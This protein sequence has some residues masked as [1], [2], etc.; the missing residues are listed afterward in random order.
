MPAHPSR[1][2]DPPGIGAYLV[3][4]IGLGVVPLVIIAA[5]LIARQAAL[6]RE[7]FERSLL[8]T[9]LALSVAVDRQLNGYQVMLET[10]AHTPELERGRID[11][12]AA[13]AAKV[14]AAHG[15]VFISLFDREGRQLFNTL[16]PA[17]T[18]LPTPFRDAR[19]AGD[20]RPPVGDAGSLKR[21]LASAGPVVSDLFHGLVADRLIFTVNIPVLREG[22]P[23]YVLNAAF[24]PEVMTR[25]LQDS[26]QFK[27]VRAVIYDRRGFIV[28]R[29]S[30]HE[31]YV[32][33][34]AG[35]ARREDLRGLP[36]GVSA[37]TT[38]DGVEVQFSFA[39]SPANGWGVN[40]AAPRADFDAVI[41]RDWM[42]GGALALL[43]LGLGLALALVLAHRLRQSIAALAG[44]ASAKQAPRVRGLRTR[45]IVQLERALRDGAAAQAAEAAEHERRVA[46][47]ARKAEAEGANRAKDHFI[48]VLSHELRNPLAAIRNAVHLLALPPQPGPPV[49]PTAEVV[50]VLARQSE[51]L[52]HLVNDLL[53]ASRIRAGKLAVQRRRIDLRTAA[54]RGIET[55][56]AAVQARGQHL[57]LELAETPVEVMG[58]AARLA[59]VA[60]NLVDNAVKFT[61]RGGRLTVVVR[62]EAGQAVL[63]VRDTGRGFDAALA[64]RL[65][66]PFAQA[67]GE[68]GQPSEG[69]LGLG[70]SLAKALVELHDGTLVAESRGPGKGSEFTVRLPLA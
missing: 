67:E 6:Q 34:L 51:Q 16:R 62:T 58:D 60:A 31:K 8:Q 69:G 42:I 52:T 22:K 70:L 26:D 64:G 18:P 12:L 65:F 56:A 9:S 30:E 59:Q 36:R 41:R 27:G 2:I 55:A 35:S 24:A 4:L 54:R 57:E 3:A 43:G 13:I 66:Q 53:D 47:E 40:V 63:R 61:D 33:T 25:L 23:V 14:A 49:V 46:A 29:W 20:A 21:V 1:P 10:L 15:A 28:G 17:G 48:A 32:G 5:V 45:E 38:L 68:A 7:A 39:R 19:S 50:A 11:E 37:G 44:A